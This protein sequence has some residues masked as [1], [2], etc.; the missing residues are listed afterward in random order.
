MQSASSSKSAKRISKPVLVVSGQVVT[1]LLAWLSTSH[2][3]RCQSGHSRVAARPRGHV[4]IWSRIATTS[5]L[6]PAAGSA[7]PVPGAAPLPSLQEGGSGALPEHQL[8]GAVDGDR[9]TWWRGQ[10]ADTTEGGRREVDG[11]VPGACVP[12]FEEVPAGALV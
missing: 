8:C 2:R 11:A 6:R 9:G 1:T 3:P 4:A 5:R 10:R 7:A 12:V